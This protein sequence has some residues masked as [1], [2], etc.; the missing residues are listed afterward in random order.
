MMGVSWGN[1]EDVLGASG[2]CLRGIWGMPVSFR[3]CWVMSGGSGEYTG[4]VWE[5]F[6]GVSGG[7]QGVEG[8]P[9][10]SGGPREYE[11]SRIYT[12]NLVRFEFTKNR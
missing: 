8:G 3:V 10:G 7:C 4:N 9:H 6:W 11:K 2:G 1:L 12:V 5:D